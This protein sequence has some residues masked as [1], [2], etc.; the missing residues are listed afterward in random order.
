MHSE[1]LRS[2]TDD[3]IRAFREEGVVLLRGLFD[4]DWVAHLRAA[5]EKGL[6]KPTV[7]GEELAQARGDG[8]R[9]FHDTFMWRQDAACRHFVFESPAA[10]IAA[11]AMGA[12]RAHIFFDQWLIKEPGS[13]T[14]T[15]W[16]HDLTYWPIQGSQVATLWLALD[17]VTAESG[18]VEYVKGSHRWGQ[19][20]KPATFSGDHD[21]SEHLPPVP[22]IDARRAELEILQF[23]MAPGDC[24]LHHGLMVHG[25]PGNQRN[26][27]RRRASVTRWAGEDVTY[28]P[29]AGLQ[30]MPQDPGIA[31]GAPLSGPL[32]PQVWPRGVLQPPDA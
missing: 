32:W 26:D 12:G 27:R 8:G 25:A 15:P 20:Y 16:H 11:R 5:A 31:S 10:E 14:R 18:A 28:A 7:F 22:D 6:S 9:F 23:E 2:V 4:A 29:R 21:Y 13:P 17:P 24:T 30:G 1:P 3:E 19:R